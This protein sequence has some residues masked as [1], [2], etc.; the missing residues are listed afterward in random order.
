MGAC[1]FDQYSILH[2]ATGVVAYFWQVPLWLFFLVHTAFEII[3]NS[4][5]GMAFI[6]QYLYRYWPG[7]KPMADSLTNTL[8]DTVF[9]LLGWAVAAFL[10]TH[11]KSQDGLYHCNNAPFSL[12]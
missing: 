3:E 8:G 2:A 9:A 1:F 4:V 11:I 12:F 7:G 5:P 10:D 6:N